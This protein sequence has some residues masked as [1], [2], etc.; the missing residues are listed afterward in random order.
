MKVLFL[1][2]RMLVDWDKCGIKYSYEFPAGKFKPRPGIVPDRLWCSLNNTCQTMITVFCLKFKYFWV[3]N[4]V[5]DA[6][7]SGA[8]LAIGRGGRET[9][10]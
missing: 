4:Y 7:I 9:T 1:K 3:F 10:L 8:I 5:S 2:I 6:C